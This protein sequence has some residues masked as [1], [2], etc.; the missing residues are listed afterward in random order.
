MEVIKKQNLVFVLAGFLFSLSMFS[1]KP[2]TFEER[3]KAQEAIERVYYNHRIWPKENKTPKP[4]FEQMVTKEVIEQKVEDYLKK[5]VALEKY[6]YRPIT[7][8][9]L[10]AE[11]ERMAKNTKDP[12]ILNEL[13]EALNNDP[14]LIAECLARPVLADRLIRNWYANDERFHKETREKAEEALKHLTPENFC[15][16][17]E[18][19]YSKITFKLSLG[20]KEVMDLMDP[21]DNSINLSKEEFYKIYDE[22][23]KEGK[24]STVIERDECFVIYHS[25]E[26]KEEIILLEII[27]FEK[28]SYEKWLKKQALDRK[29]VDANKEDSYAI[30]P[31]KENQC[32]ERWDNGTLY[33]IPTE[34]INHTAIWTGTEMIIWGGERGGGR[35]LSVSKYWLKI[36]S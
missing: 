29:I 3:F 36:L 2:L 21:K 16:Y 25:I 13:F 20:R 23:P 26:K 8:E 1:Y 14:Y 24:L 6:W 28:I 18:G 9:Q 32:E 10:Q 27:R 19:K 12:K 11:I 33:N 15:S 17:S 30:P 35:A 4:P 5:S 31:I 7:G 34:R 22:V